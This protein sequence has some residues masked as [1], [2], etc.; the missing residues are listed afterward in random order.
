MKPLFSVSVLLIGA[1]LTPLTM[2]ATQTAQATAPQPTAAQQGNCVGTPVKKPT[3]HKPSARHKR[4]VRSQSQS[5]SAKLA[6]PPAAAEKAVVILSPTP[7][8]NISPVKAPEPLPLCEPRITNP[9]FSSYTV[10]EIQ[11]RPLFV[12]TVRLPEPV[13]SIAAGAPTFFEAAHS[14]DDA[15]LV[16]IKPTTHDP[17][18]INI[19]IALQ[20]GDM[21]SLR[22][23]SGGDHCAAAKLDYILDYRTPRS[24]LSLSGEMNSPVMAAG[25]AHGITPASL[26]VVKTGHSKVEAHPA[27]GE[28]KSI[29]EALDKQ[30][31]ITAPLWVTATDLK[32]AIKANEN[33]PTTVAVSVGSVVQNG[34]TMTITYSVLNVSSGWVQILPPQVQLAGPANKKSGKKHAAL[35]EELPIQEFRLPVSKLSPGARTDGAVQFARPGFKQSKEAMLLQIATA[36]AVDTPLLMPIP[37]VAAGK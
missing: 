34:E 35:A 9:P 18:E 30:A 37:F 16:F 26:P 23:F 27:V 21:V 24:L 36:S 14:D 1:M 6:T 25:P 28:P 15:R 33:A 29:D 4:A 31:A 13:S 5:A 8:V 11:L 20:T 12:T 3:Q 32:K 22:V 19:L 2:A 7:L 17:F 10:T